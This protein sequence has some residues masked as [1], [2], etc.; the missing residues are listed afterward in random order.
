MLHLLVTLSLVQHY[1]LNIRC[2]CVVLVFSTVEV[3]IIV[4]FELAVRKSGKC[5]SITVYRVTW[6]MHAG[7]VISTFTH[8]K[9]F[10]SHTSPIECH[11][12]LV[13]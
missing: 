7:R 13:V 10:I 12:G 1:V 6:V 11:H 4:L 3:K 5:L 9:T 8:Q 2:D